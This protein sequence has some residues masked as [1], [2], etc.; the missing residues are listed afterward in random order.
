MPYGAEY[1]VPY[2]SICG[3]ILADTGSTTTLINEEF[4]HR[5]GLEIHNTGKDLRLRDVNN[6]LSDLTD[7][8]Y[9][10]LTLTTVLGE[11]ITLVTLA[12]CVKGLGQDLLLGTRDLER[13][14]LSILPHRGEAHMQIGN[15]IEIFPMLDKLQISRLQEGL[16][17]KGKFGC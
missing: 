11:K 15:T 5:Q 10:R 9:L 12:H 2:S 14:Q 4:A 7:Y 13:Y 3:M 17:K 6:G 1:L 16:S 8:C